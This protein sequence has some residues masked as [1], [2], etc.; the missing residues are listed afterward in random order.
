MVK[1]SNHKGL[2]VGLA[3]AGI[4][5]AAAGAYFLYGSKDAEKNR[6]KVK[7][8]AIKAKGEALEL[9]EKAELLDAATYQGIIDKVI[10]KAGSSMEDREALKKELLS[11]WKKIKDHVGSPKSAMKKTAAKAKKKMSS[12]KKMAKKMVKK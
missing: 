3:A 11:Y 9:I 8:W 4:A 10:T 1:K 6:K 5:A 2:K 7:G 12:A